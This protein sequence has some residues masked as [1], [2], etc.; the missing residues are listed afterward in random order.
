MEY[1]FG[2]WVVRRRVDAGFHLRI[3]EGPHPWEREVFRE[4][5]EPG[6]PEKPLRCMR[7]RDGVYLQLHFE[8]C[9]RL[10]SWQ[11]ESDFGAAG[12]TFCVLCR[13]YV[14]VGVLSVFMTFRRIVSVGCGNG[15]VVELVLPQALAVDFI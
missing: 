10:Q 12:F 1:G 7:H 8:K 5:Q 4:N 2:L 3:V 13:I 14:F 11:T 9:V 6:E 15:S